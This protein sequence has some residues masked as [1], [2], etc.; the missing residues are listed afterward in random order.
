MSAVYKLIQ[1]FMY[2]SVY[3][4]QMFICHRSIIWIFN[5]LFVYDEQGKQYKHMQMCA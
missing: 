2:K 3:I 5:A 1:T 4:L